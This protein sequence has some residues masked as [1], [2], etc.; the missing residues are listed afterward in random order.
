[1]INADIINRSV[2]AVIII[3]YVVAVLVCGSCSTITN[4]IAGPTVTKRFGLEGNIGM[5]SLSGL[6]VCVYN[7]SGEEKDLQRRT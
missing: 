5:T 3:V 2:V 7:Y 6:S 4:R 1:M